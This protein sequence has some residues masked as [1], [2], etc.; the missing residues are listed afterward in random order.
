MAA[1]HPTLI[2]FV[3]GGDQPI[4]EPISLAVA[5]SAIEHG[6]APLVDDAVRTERLSAEREALV[7]LAM[8]SMDSTVATS[9]AWKALD[10]LL[11]TADSVGVEIG[12]FKGLASGTRWY[13]RPD[14]RPAV[15][16]DVFISPDQSDRMGEFVEAVTGRS[17]SRAAVEAMVSEGRVFEYTML[18]DGVTVDLHID[19]MN[20]VVLTRRRHDLWDRLDKIETVTG[21]SIGA[22]DLELSIVQALLH[23]FRDNFADLLH[24]YD[25]GL[26]LDEEPDFGFIASYTDAEGI[27]DPIRF[28]VAVV[29]DV[30]GRP[31]PLPRR[32]SRSNSW[33]I[34]AIW[35]KRIRLNGNESISRSYRRQ[36]LASLLVSGRRREVTDALA[37]RAF[38]PRTVIDDR[39]E[40][41]DCPYPIALLRWRLAQRRENRSRQ[42][43]QSTETT[44]AAL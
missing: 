3:R 16:V 2:E 42:P 6:L 34:R 36:S 38:P 28:S 32:I 39:F 33:L 11:A 43:V 26:M 12:V 30:L 13:P 41:C 22:M 20:L 14:L 4:D 31:S 44:H 29:S 5:V 17:S 35:P 21:R 7:Q 9:A 25:V 1:P 37:R 15:D 40:G 24:I 8:S 27:T 18:V 19:P 10:T 23:L